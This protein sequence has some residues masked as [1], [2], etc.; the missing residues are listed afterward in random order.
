VEIKCIKGGQRENNV[1]TVKW[2]TASKKPGSSDPRNENL[3]QEQNPRLQINR[4]AIYKWSGACWHLQRSVPFF[5][6]LSRREEER[7]S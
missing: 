3:W 4:I 2:Q 5:T 7:I 1:S 6:P